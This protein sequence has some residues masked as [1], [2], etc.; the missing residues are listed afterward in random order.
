MFFSQVGKPSSG[1]GEA[2]LLQTGPTEHP[3][4]FWLLVE[5]GNSQSK[6]PGEFSGSWMFA[7]LLDKHVKGHFKRRL[8]DLG[9]GFME[10]TGDVGHHPAGP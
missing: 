6:L 10:I 1:P 9:G 2:P 5:G 8:L 3:K 4:S 7:A